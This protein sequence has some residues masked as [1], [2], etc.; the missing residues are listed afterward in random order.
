MLLSS[1][2]GTNG[3]ISTQDFPGET[4]YVDDDF[5]TDFPVIAPFLAD[6]DTSGGRGDIYYRQDRAPTV[7]EWAAG[8]VH[9]GFPDTAGTFVPSSAFIATWE[10]VGAHGEPPRKVG[11]DTQ[12]WVRITEPS[13]RGVIESWT[14][15]EGTFGGHP[16]WVFLVQH[17]KWGGRAC[18]LR[19]R[20]VCLLAQ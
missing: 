17:P 13:K 4:Q 12:R 15:L 7:L 2:V 9:A 8:Y 6:L 1:Q 3:V 18:P 11:L 5:P 19:S 14:E 20:W 16:G 10:D